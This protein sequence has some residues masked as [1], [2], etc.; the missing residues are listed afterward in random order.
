MFQLVGT[1][2]DF[3][4]CWIWCTS[5]GTT[6]SLHSSILFFTTVNITMN[7][8]DSRSTT[9]ST[10]S[11]ESEQLFSDLRVSLQFQHFFKPS[12]G[13]TDLDV[14]SFPVHWTQKTVSATTKEEIFHFLRL[15]PPEDT[16][17]CW[18]WG[19]LELQKVQIQKLQQP[20]VSAELLRL[21]LR[22]RSYQVL[23]VFV[24]KTQHECKTK[25]WRTI[26]QSKLRKSDQTGW[27]QR[28]KVTQTENSWITVVH[29]KHS[30]SFTK[31]LA[32]RYYY[33]RGFGGV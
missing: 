4:R 11:R 29:C 3:D 30:L 2:L 21:L 10:R 32:M 25:P 26:L 12:C 5:G 23:S 28:N 14:D 13:E 15:F 6:I 31:L 27:K 7:R 16:S 8:D 18:R 1:F 20:F 17:R 33:P 24:L 19:H 22:T 9:T